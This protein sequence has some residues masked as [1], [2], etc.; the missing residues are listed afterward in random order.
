MDCPNCRNFISS[1]EYSAHPSHFCKKCL[2]KK[3]Q[4]D[5]DANFLQDYASTRRIHKENLEFVRIV[6]NSGSE[7]RIQAISLFERDLLEEASALLNQAESLNKGFST[8]I[9]FIG[10]TSQVLW[11]SIKLA[12]IEGWVSSKMEKAAETRESKAYKL[13]MKAANE[14]QFFHVNTIM[15]IENQNPD[16]WV[17]IEEWKDVGVEKIYAMASA[18]FIKIRTTEGVVMQLNWNLLEQYHL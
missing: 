18:S 10:S 8:G 5:K 2:E 12:A 1:A 15:N 3:V 9:G 17:A 14:Q 13:L 11:S 7:I 16:S 4:A 6:M